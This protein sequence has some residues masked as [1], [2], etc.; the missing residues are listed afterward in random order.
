M[1]RAAEVGLLAVTLAGV[2][3]IGRLLEG[4]TWVVP[5]GASALVAHVVVA[6][7]RRRGVPLPVAALVTLTVAVLLVTWAGYGATTT[8]GLPTGETWTAVGDDL[9]AAWEVFR[10]DSPPA[11]AEPGFLLI[12]SL[13][14]WFVVFVA[15]WAAF[16]LWV[17]FEATLPASTLFLF[18]AVLGSDRG[19]GPITAVFAAAALAFLLLHR[20]A[21]REGTSHWVADRRLRGQRSL[22][23]L[24]AVLVAVAVAVGSLA[25]PNLPGAEAEAII[26]TRRSLQD[27]GSRVTISPLVDIRARLIQQANVEVFRIRSP[28]RAYW[29]LTSLERFDGRIWSSSGSFAR[30]GE[31]LP[32]SGEQ[33]AVE[34]P[35]EQVVTVAALAQIWLPAAYEPRA[36]DAPGAE[37][38]YDDDSSTLIVERERPSSDGL[39][40]RVVSA[41]PRFTADELRTADG[42]IPGD[43]GDRY[44]GLPPDLP[45]EVHDLARTVTAGAATPYDRAMALQQHLRG[46]TYDLGVEPGHGSSA[47]VDFL[48]VTQRGYC[49]QFAGAFAAMARAVG[50]PARVAV[51]FTPGDPDPE[52]PTVLRV[53]GEHAHAWPEV[54]LAG[55]GWVAFEPTPG[56]GAPFAEPYTGVP[57]QQAATGDAA[58]ATTLAPAEA[59]EAPGTG[60]GSATTAPPAALPDQQPGALPEL[61]PQPDGTEAPTATER[62]APRVATAAGVLLALVAAYLVAVPTARAVQRRRRRSRAGDD[63]TAR[64]QAAWAEGLE[65]LELVGLAIAPSHTHAE[66]ATLA[67]AVLPDAAPDAARLARAVE[68]AD[69]APGGADGTQADAADEAVGALGDAVRAATTPLQRFTH[70]VHPRRVL[71]R[72]RRTG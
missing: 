46:F 51:G 31:T 58:T 3:C 9:A 68:Q 52:D 61:T 41:A 53:R 27:P 59:P 35:V 4:T 29:R 60:E 34:A 54:Y 47:L 14:I 39:T 30:A 23:G 17:P 28:E 56:R 21:R 12:S 50:L 19:R 70:L 6:L 7:L 18:A 42:S 64:V 66:V 2:V 13:A 43:V 40:Y 62:W 63:P 20:T 25:G 38:R 22:L 33:L 65:D 72:R 55:Y 10:E 8:I 49:E 16:R 48:F 44:L 32:T 36:I 15:D 69:Y 11:P 26:E 67:G 37:V 45:A 5:L 71:R 57:E 1:V 24:G